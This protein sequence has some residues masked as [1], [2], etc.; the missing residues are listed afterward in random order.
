MFA[1]ILIKIIIILLLLEMQADP[2][3]ATDG[4]FIPLLQFC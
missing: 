1:I 3:L 4:N 2:T